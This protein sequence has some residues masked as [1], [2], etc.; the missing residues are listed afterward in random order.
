MSKEIVSIHKKIINPLKYSKKEREPAQKEHLYP[1][2]FLNLTSCKNYRIKSRFIPWLWRHFYTRELD[3]S[4]VTFNDG[5]HC[6]S[7]K[8][9]IYIGHMVVL[10]AS[11]CVLLIFLVGIFLRWHFFICA[12]QMARTKCPISRTQTICIIIFCGKKWYND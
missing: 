7:P 6:I 12:V 9:L 8:Q 4:Q 1:F 5:L 2:L 10:W 11:S 3:V